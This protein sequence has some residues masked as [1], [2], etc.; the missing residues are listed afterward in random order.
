M[1]QK[2]DTQ[3]GAGQWL[4]LRDGS[5]LNALLKKEVGIEMVETEGYS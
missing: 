5:A 3:L 1:H 2:E 4:Y